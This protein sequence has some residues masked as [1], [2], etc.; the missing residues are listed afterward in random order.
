MLISPLCL[1]FIRRI[2]E[3]LYIEA[4]HWGPVFL[5]DKRITKLAVF[6]VDATTTYKDEM[7]NYYKARSG[8]FSEI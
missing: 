7:P 2:H 6:S 5:E 4:S 3:N 1:D 8:D